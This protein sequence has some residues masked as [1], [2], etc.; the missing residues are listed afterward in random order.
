VTNSVLSVAKLLAGSVG[1]MQPD[2]GLN[3]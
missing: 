3:I 2:D 1:L